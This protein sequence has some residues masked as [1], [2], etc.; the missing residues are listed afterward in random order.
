MTPTRYFT[1]WAACDKYVDE[2]ID[3]K[4]TGK[5]S[6]ANAPVNKLNDSQEKSNSK[7]I[8]FSK[9]SK[10]ELIDLK[11]KTRHEYWAKRPK[12]AKRKHLKTGP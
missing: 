3:A 7:Q 11:R 8:D 10:R 4:K 1:S 9:L 2:L 6:P 5:S 12:R